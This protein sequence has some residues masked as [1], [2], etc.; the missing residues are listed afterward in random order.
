MEVGKRFC[1]D[2]KGSY[3]LNGMDGVACL[4]EAAALFKQMNLSVCSEELEKIKRKAE[5]STSGHVHAGKIGVH[6]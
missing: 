1:E 6:A 5:L 2:G 3:K 4:E